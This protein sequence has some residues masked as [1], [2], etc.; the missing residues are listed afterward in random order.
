MLCFRRINSYSLSG[1]G[2][3]LNDVKEKI[4]E[5]L[6]QITK[7][8]GNGTS[9]HGTGDHGTSGNG[10]GVGFPGHYRIHHANLKKTYFLILD[11][12]SFPTL[13]TQ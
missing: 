7:K 9:G 8:E 5:V 1:I 3:K 2:E 11:L 4:D 13:K 10:Q 6:F 12:D